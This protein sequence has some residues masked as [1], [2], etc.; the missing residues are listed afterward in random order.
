[1]VSIA[2]CSSSSTLLSRP[3]RQASTSAVRNTT[4][5]PPRHKLFQFYQTKIPIHVNRFVV[6]NVIS[7][8]NDL[9]TSV[10]GSITSTN[11]QKSIEEPFTRDIHT[12]SLSLLEWPELS[13]H[14]LRYATSDLGRLSLT[15]GK[16]SLLYIPSTQV[17]SEKLL[18]QTR[19]VYNLEYNLNRPLPISGVSNII[20]ITQLA[21]KGKLLSGKELLSISSTLFSALAVRKHLDALPNPDSFHALISLTADMRTCAE[22]AK[23]IRSHL[24]DF[25][26]VEESADPELRSIRSETREVVSDI[27]LALNTLMSRHADSVQERLITS[28]YD[29]FVIPVKMTRKS[30]FRRAI[31]HDTSSS[32]GTAFIEPASVRPLNDRVRMLT[33]RERARVNAILRKLCEKYIAPNVDA[34]VQAARI[35]GDL[36]A[37][38]ARARCSRSLQAVDVVFD[39]EKPLR[40]LGARHPLLVWK[41]MTKERA[42]DDKEE[43][44]EN[45]NTETG[46]QIDEKIRKFKLPLEPPWKKNVV[47]SS[48]ELNEH[49]RCVCVT[50]PNT[51]GKT[52]SLKTLGVC[53][54]M[55][56]AGLFVPSTIPKVLSNDNQLVDDEESRRAR[57]PFF[58]HVLADIGDD[59]SL[60]QSLSTFSGHVQRIK[61]IIAAS[62]PQSLVLLDEIGSGT[63]SLILSN[64]NLKAIAF[65]SQCD[66]YPN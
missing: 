18:A 55:A 56:K 63:V 21:A 28:R 53:V 6:C 57:I 11:E 36:D 33:V 20:E 43:E 27:R 29:R 51:G 66:V 44:R 10:P 26:D 61:R 31:V 14:I 64:N 37:A 47:P 3:K 41:E 46:D 1:M 32:G 34:I 50:G 30:D 7:S 25:G 17:E 42:L 2:F 38:V 45:Y 40:L 4:F 60:V 8:S 9:V 58:D 22:A 5:C 35:L 13:Q 52:L 12:E 48:Y 49:V 19:E 65:P 15:N 54:L 23:E 39:N 16:P 59:Q 62:T 24:D